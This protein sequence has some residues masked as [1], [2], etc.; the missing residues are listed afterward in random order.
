MTVN[1]RDFPPETLAKYNI[2]V[3]HPD[4]FI[5]HQFGLNHARTVIAAK[6]C[7]GRLR[8]PS[9]TAEEYLSTLAAQGLPKTVAELSEY[10]D[11]I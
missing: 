5:H 8:N 11:V 1:L 10:A 2:E 7:R 4:D 3:L 9:K 6:A